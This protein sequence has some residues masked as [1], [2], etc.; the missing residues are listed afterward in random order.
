MTD[1]E[2]EAIKELR[3]SYELHQCEWAKRCLDTIQESFD[4]KDKRIDELKETTEY[5]R[6]EF[7]RVLTEK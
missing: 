2:K 5:W 3:D 6:K 1:E 7:E 4:K